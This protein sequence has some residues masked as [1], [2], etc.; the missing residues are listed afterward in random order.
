MVKAFFAR[1]VAQHL[2]DDLLRRHVGIDRPEILTFNALCRSRIRIGWRRIQHLDKVG[3]IDKN[4]RITPALDIHVEEHARDVV[5]FFVD[6]GHPADFYFLRRD[7]LGQ[8]L[9]DIFTM[10]VMSKQGD[11]QGE[12]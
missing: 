7:K 8:I 11:R 6:S 4:R 9:E 2:R 12:N 1:L 3:S 5:S 10:A